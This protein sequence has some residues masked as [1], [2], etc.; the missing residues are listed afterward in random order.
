MFDSFEL[1]VKISNI[2]WKYPRN[3]HAFIIQCKFICSEFADMELPKQGEREA[4][5]ILGCYFSLRNQDLKMNQTNW[6]FMQF[7]KWLWLNLKI[8]TEF[9]KNQSYFYGRSSNSFF[10][11]KYSYKISHLKNHFH[12]FNLQKL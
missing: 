8:K 9:F 4:I 5:Q 1:R 7:I 3:V 10:S 11:N 12:W 2:F 6:L